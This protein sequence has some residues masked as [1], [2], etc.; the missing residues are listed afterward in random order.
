MSNVRRSRPK[1]ARPGLITRPD[2]QR[3][4]AGIRDITAPAA[5]A[6]ALGPNCYADPTGPGPACLFTLGL[7][8]SLT[9]TPGYDD[10]TGIGPHRAPFRCE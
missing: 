1:N 2:R 8:S 10:V 9:E 5:P 3:H 6:L 7:D 4:S